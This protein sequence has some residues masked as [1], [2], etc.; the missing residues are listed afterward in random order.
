MRFS[1]VKFG[2]Q[3]TEILF[4]RIDDVAHKCTE[5]TST[6]CILPKENIIKWYMYLK[7]FIPKNKNRKKL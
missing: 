2:F 3:V 6:K 1:V 4:D 5:N 7:P